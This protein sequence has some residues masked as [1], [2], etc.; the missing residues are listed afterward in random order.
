MIKCARI[1]IIWQHGAFLTAAV[2]DAQHCT[3][4][5]QSDT[6]AIREGE[7]PVCCFYEHLSNKCIFR[8][9]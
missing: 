3:F 9:P 2:L 4:I 1:N 5:S 6:F 8:V 7:H